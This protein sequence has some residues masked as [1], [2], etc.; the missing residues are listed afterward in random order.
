MKTAKM[1]MKTISLICVLTLICNNSL[2]AMPLSLQRDTLAP[3][4]MFDQEERLLAD[5]SGRGKYVAGHAA[6][7]DEGKLLKQL[8]ISYRLIKP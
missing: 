7:V 5:A 4:S 8:T 3:G 1:F 2:Y 6:V